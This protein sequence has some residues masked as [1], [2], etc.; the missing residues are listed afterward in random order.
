MDHIIVDWTITILGSLVAI[1]G[2]AIGLKLASGR[3]KSISEDVFHDRLRILQEENKDL[4]NHLKR[5]IGTVSQMK[6]GLTLPDGTNLEEQKEGG[7]DG[8]IKGLI[9]KYSSMAPPQLRPFL[10]D[11]A[12]VGFLLEEAKKNPEQTKEVLK[13]FM[14]T[15]GK[16][17]PQSSSN[18]SEN[19]E[20][21][22]AEGA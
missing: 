11:P 3:G 2:G 20:S 16:I 18:E 8:I 6:Q 12:I 5:Q 1:I 14:N 9:G 19:L 4:K 21:L 17:G 10:Q 13:H 7:F 22:T 15:N